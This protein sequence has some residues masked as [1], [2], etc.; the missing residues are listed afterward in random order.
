MDKIIYGGDTET[1]AGKPN[2]LQ[3]YSEDIACDEIIFCDEK[4][5]AK[6]FLQWCGRRQ[7]DCQ[8][9][10]Y[11]HNL[12]FDLIE[13][14]YGFHAKLIGVGGEFNF[15]VG[16]WNVSGVYGAPTFC[17]LSDGHKRS[18]L[19]I[20]SFSFYRGSLDSAAKLFCPDLPKLRRPRDLGSV[21]YGPR[22]TNFCAYAMRDA[23]IGYHIGRQIERLHVEFD[24]QQCVSVADLAARVF[25]HRFLTYTIPQPARD[26]IEC[27]LLSYHGGKN[28]IAAPAGWYAGVNALDISSAYPHAMASLPSF[29]I[30][31]AYR[32]I[33]MR[34]P[35]EVPALGVYR[36]TGKV[37]ACK[38]P[39]LFSHAFK[40]LQGKVDD[41]CVQGFELNEAIRSGEAKIS[42]VDGWYYDA[43]K[44]GGAP[45][46]RAFCND[47]YARKEKEK[48]KVLRY[49]YKLIL[50][51]I[52]GKFIQ[53]RKTSKVAYVDLDE[54]T[55]TMACE[56]IAGGM[57]HP[58]IAS[59]ITAHTRARIH[60]LEHK[61][62]ALHTA[63]DGIMTQRAVTPDR[64]KKLG[65]LALEAS[66]DLLL[67]RN[68]LYILYNGSGEIKS[69]AFKSKRIAKYALHGFQGR[70]HDLEQLIA[71][72][73]RKYTVNKP[74]R[75]RES[76][77]RK[78]QPNEFTER[79]FVLKVGEIPLR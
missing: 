73:R 27:A 22:D 48:D 36:V 3:F 56:L 63:T 13:L 72:G 77:K 78:L 52:S 74:H 38:W 65:A 33:V 10:V 69:R 76:I 50:N 75:L 5:A 20:D 12:E 57:F 61:Y 51:S 17:R 39:V 71:T 49:M 29:G 28:N 47:F 26:V 30:E 32:H 2:S 67:V 59:T 54:G 34:N 45:A 68:K 40:P 53:T 6:K 7:Q 44:D 14:L 79:E 19:L 1:V 64:T 25:R 60:Q 15:K 18:I 70:V 37:D 41:L 11:I 8:H 46:L 66:G 55:A 31:K 9:V 35:R 43:D 24:L 62:Q 42:R 58:F 16:K 23:E 21:R 4:S